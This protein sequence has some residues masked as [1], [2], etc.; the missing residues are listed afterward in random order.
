MCKRNRRALLLAG[1]LLLL[2]TAVGVTYALITAQSATARNVFV[3][4]N[5]R[6]TLTEEFTDADGNEDYSAGGLGGEAMFVEGSSF[7]KKPT[8]TV[9]SGSLD[10][11]LRL[12]V[13]IEKE[14]SGFLSGAPDAAENWTR[15]EGSPDSDGNHVYY[16]TYG[17]VA[18]SGFEASPFSSVYFKDDFGGDV[19]EGNG[20]F[21]IVAQAVQSVEGASAEEAFGGVSFE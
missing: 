17:A 6:L 8:V 3:M 12:K 10:C 4:G 15:T 19:Y 16:Y 21:D 2:L 14:L 1:I 5:I 18:G 20:S 11:Y 7:I 9:E 13:T